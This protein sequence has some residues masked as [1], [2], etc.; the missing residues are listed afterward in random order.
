MRAAGLTRQLLLFSRR[1]VP[2]FEPLDLNESINGLM[3]MLR[4]LLGASI[5][6][7]FLPSTEAAWVR[8]D[9]GMLEQ[10]VLNLCINARDAMSK[11]G[12]LTL[13]T[14]TVERGARSANSHLDAR[15]G[16][17]VCVSVTDTGCGM[18]ETVLRRLF[19]PLFT[20]KAAGKGTGLG[21]ATIQGIVR[22]HEGWTEVESAVGQGSTFRVYLPAQARPASASGS[23]S[24]EAI[25]GGSETI[26]LV[27]D[28]PSVRR[29]VALC[30]R[31]LGYAVLEAGT[32]LEALKAW[33]E[34]HEAIKLLFTDMVMPG[35]MTGL[36]LS[37]RLRKEKASLKVIISSG[38][39]EDPA[40][41]PPTGAQEI[42]YLAK[43]YKAT[44]L[45]KAVR[46][47]LDRT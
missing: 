4:R 36:D 17:F 37:E 8:A 27:E 44:A 28:E 7:K 38:Y 18:D 15:A 32:G 42:T 24:P 39:N 41:P 46:S 19:E 29:T 5:E 11:G 3:K 9:A 45:A 2:R 33:E 23:P 43:P 26:L 16:C 31:K 21:L 30:L 35:A 25:K 6:V 1:Q 14:T 13:V 34:H 10:V 22:Q 20:T 40:A 12:R 47:C